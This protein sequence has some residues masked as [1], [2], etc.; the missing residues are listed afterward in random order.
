MLLRNCLPGTEDYPDDLVLKHL[1]KLDI[2]GFEKIEK[3]FGND[4]ELYG[5]EKEGKI[6]KDNFISDFVPE[7][8]IRSREKN[9]KALREGLTLDG[10]RFMIESYF[11]LHL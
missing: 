5:I 7:Y 2:G 9:L 10:K 6:T 11:D 3:H 4:F 8:V 1:S